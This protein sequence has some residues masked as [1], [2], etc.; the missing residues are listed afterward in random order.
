[1]LSQMCM[2]VREVYRFATKGDGCR[3]RCLY[4]AGPRVMGCYV[5][6]IGERRRSQTWNLIYILTFLS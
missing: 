4:L 2:D 1:M 6:V 5:S 3:K